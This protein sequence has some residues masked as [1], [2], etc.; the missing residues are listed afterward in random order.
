MLISL[1]FQAKNQA[2]PAVQG[3]K[4]EIGQV[5][6]AAQDSQKQ[7]EKLSDAIAWGMGKA[8]LAIGSAQSAVGFLQNAFQESTK[9]QLDNTATAASF[10]ALT[11]RSYDEASNFVNHL[12]DSLSVAAA[13]LPGT[14][15]GYKDLAQAIQAKIIPAFED[16]SGAIDFKGLD[17]G[18][19]DITKSFGV[20]SAQYGVNT[21]EASG[22]IN[23]FIEGIGGV[24]GLA[25]TSLG[26]KSPVVSMLKQEIQQTGKSMEALTQQERF[27]IL[28]AV[29]NRL[30][31]PDVIKRTTGTVSGLVE[32]FKTQLFDATSGT[33]G[34]MRN[35]AP[36]G[37][38]RTSAFD[39]INEAINRIIGDQGFVVKVGELLSA[40]GIKLLDPMVVLKS[41]VDA[42]SGAIQAV[43]DT[44]SYA[45]TYT[46]SGEGSLGDF[47]GTLPANLGFDQIGDKIKAGA[48]YVMGL[49]QNFNLSEV[50]AGIEDF[51]KSLPKLVNGIIHLVTDT[52]TKPSTGESLSGGMNFG[53][54]LGITLGIL[55]G[56]AIN[57]LIYGIDWG[58]VFVSIGNVAIAAIGVAAGLIGGFVVSGIST[59]AKGLIEA[60]PSILLN[61]AYLELTFFSAVGEWFESASSATAKVGAS[62]IGAV[63][64][65]VTTKWAEFTDSVVSQFNAIIEQLRQF[66][67]SAFAPFKNAIDAAQNSVASVTST[68]S[69]IVSKPMEAISSVGSSVLNAINPS[70]SAAGTTTTSPSTSPVPTVTI[71]EPSA[72]HMFGGNIPHAADGLLGAAIAESRNMPSGAQLVVANDS[73]YILSPRGDAGVTNRGVS[74]GNINIYGVNDAVA[75]ADSVIAE[76]ESRLVAYQSGYLG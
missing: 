33:F 74:I 61:F 34:L 44:L 23:K 3:L 49:V 27:Q 53:T 62:A 39:S 8:E 65:L 57:F 41:G 52:L 58:A 38:V 48:S 35:L 32:S 21:Q 15:Q 13:A 30:V 50:N 75:I 29:G 43:N 45:V 18:L 7:S 56:N 72:A 60:T 71:S 76:I 54:Q 55:A 68:F 64:G 40:L 26:I 16:A 9:L 46:K 59:L 51:F 2:S 17:S 31:T 63:V 36:E 24:E 37:E 10:A 28:K 5:G 73:E 69:G 6:Q 14:T 20:L 1:I 67:T 42:F 12:N 19:Q 70:P 66:F 47:I 22:L 4:N 25:Q 11:N